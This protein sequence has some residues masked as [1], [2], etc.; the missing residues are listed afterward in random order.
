MS[1]NTIVVGAPGHKVGSNA[2]QG[3]VLVFTKPAAG[4]AN[5]TASTMLTASD[6]DAGDELGQWLS[7]N[8]NTIVASASAHGA[9]G[10]AYV[11]VEHNGTWGPN[12]TAELTPP[13]SPPKGGYMQVAISPD[14]DTI[15][16]GQ[17]NATV[18]GH[19]E[20]GE[21]LAFTMPAG[22]WAAG[23]PQVATLT[24]SD[25]AA[26]DLDGLEVA[27]SD[28]TIA[29]TGG[30]IGD[31]SQNDAL[32][33]FVKGAGGWM[34][35]TQTAEL[36]DA[37]TEIDVDGSVTL[38]ISPD[39]R[40]VVAGITNNTSKP[41]GAA[42]VYA[43]GA[44]GWAN[45]TAPSA[46]LAGSDGAAGDIFGFATAASNDTIVV[47]APQHGAPGND[48]GE[49][50]VF[51]EPAGGWSGN[52]TETQKFTGA[53]PQSGA[54]GYS[55]A[56]DGTTI[57]AGTRAHQQ[58]AFVFTNPDLTTTTTG[59]SAP[60]SLSAPPAITGS[61]KA[62]APLRCST[63]R[64][65]NNP[66]RFTYQWSR[67]GTPIAGATA[68]S[69]KVQSSDEGLTLT[70]T[71]VASNAKGGSSPA[72]SKRVT[73]PVPKVK[74][75]PPATGDVSGTKLGL[76]KLGM[77][78]SQARHAYRK[79]TTRGQKYKD[80]F[81]L[82][83]RGMRDGYGSPKEPKKYRDRVIWISTSSA[84]YTVHGIRVGATIPNTESILKLTGPYIVGKN[85][86]YFTRNGTSNAIFKVRH[87][88]IQ[89]IGIA[90]KGLTTGKKA[91][92]RFLTSFS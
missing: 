17:E 34:S 91:Q 21:V 68:S 46:T 14:G 88:L 8:G 78:R 24:A 47:A 37:S 84:Y 49:L 73:V 59:P 3:A 36:T 77:T 13:G 33:V 22:G 82:T 75:C 61:P 92:R 57:V 5:S 2:S 25:G 38:S 81:C 32:Y 26:S 51:D 16:V 74:G 6:G 31:G 60:P 70:C 76:L 23:T 66:T 71:V 50:Y 90:Q 20:Q 44:G 80:F 10:A 63:G 42:I 28:S 40:T 55:L 52:L 4:W 7:M 15:A 89:E 29:A 1:G 18:N 87:G 30:T 53:T 41:D 65:T 56:F 43:E 45:A 62:G 35:G 85:T 72:T 67:G 11:F 69:Y 48:E 64:W 54:V 39:G 83:P 27:A 86:W 19:L 9:S 58:G 12:Q 79:S